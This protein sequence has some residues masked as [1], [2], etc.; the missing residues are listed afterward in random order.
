MKLADPSLLKNQCLVDGKWVGEGTRPIANPAT[1]AVLAKTP[2][3]GEAETIGAIEAAQRAFGPWAKALPKERAKIIRRWFD[4]IIANRDDIAL[5]MTSE[6][7]K[8]LAEARGEVDYAAGLS[9]FTARRPSASRRGQPDLPRGC[10]HGHRQAADR[11]RRG[12]HAVEFPGGDD[13]SQGRAGDCRRLHRG[14]E[15]RGGDAADRAGAWRTGAARRVY[16]PASST[17]SPAMRAPSARRC[18]KIRRCA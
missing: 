17:S 4:L 11:R 14:G 9:S 7:G 5:I 10:A 8:P 3:F 13:H 1:G 15:A 16:R 6:Q 12:D 2:R 18:P